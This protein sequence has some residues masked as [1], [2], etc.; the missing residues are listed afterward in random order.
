[1]AKKEIT[2]SE[3]NDGKC[4]VNVNYYDEKT[5]ENLSSEQ[6]KGIVEI[7]GNITRIEKTGESK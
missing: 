4:N 7:T 3:I 2:H 6:Y 5:E 1:M